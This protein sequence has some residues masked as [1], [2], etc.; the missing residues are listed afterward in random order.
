MAHPYKSKADDGRGVA[1]ARYGSTKNLDGPSSRAAMPHKVET[2]T[3][4]MQHKKQ[5]A[6]SGMKR[7][8]AVA[9]GKGSAPSPSFGGK[10]AGAGPSP[11]SAPIKKAGGGKVKNPKPATIA[12]APMVDVPSFQG[13]PQDKHKEI[14]RIVKDGYAR[15]GA[16]KYPLKK[17]GSESGVGRLEKAKAY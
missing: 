2:S 17:G 4:T 6:A 3:S 1:A 10:K 16:I 13:D 7:G 5:S 12:P 8:G 15:G 9:S 14:R 11:A